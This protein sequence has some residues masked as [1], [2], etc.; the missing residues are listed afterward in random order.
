RWSAHFQQAVRQYTDA[1]GRIMAIT[2]IGSG[3][4]VNGMVKAQLN[5]EAAPKTAQLHRLEKT[6]TTKVSALG[7]FRS[8]LSTFQS[9]LSKLNDASLFEKRNAT[10]SNADIVSVKADSAAGAGS[11]NLQVFNLAQS[12]KVAL[13]G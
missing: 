13:A 2:G 1:E 7:Q 12:S 4:D 10:S 6:T 5:A 8:A 3:M 9:T 11:Y